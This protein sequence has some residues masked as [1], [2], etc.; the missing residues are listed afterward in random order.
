MT[1]VPF[2]R[3]PTMLVKSKY[4]RFVQAPTSPGRKTQVWMVLSARSGDPLGLILWRSTWRQ[5]VLE[6]EPMTVWS[7]GC[8]EDVCSFIRGLMAARR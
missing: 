6:P 2:T 3:D 1:P 8:L 5:Y 4:L 7:S